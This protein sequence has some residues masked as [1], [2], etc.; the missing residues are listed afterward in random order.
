M[1]SDNVTLITA[2]KKTDRVMAERIEDQRA[3]ILRA[4]NLIRTTELSLGDALDQRG[5]LEAAYEVLDEVALELN[6]ISSGQ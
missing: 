5:T 1:A 4:M 6:A 2:A 3:L